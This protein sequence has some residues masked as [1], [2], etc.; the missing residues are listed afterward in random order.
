MAGHFRADGE[1]EFQTFF[2]GFAGEYVE[3]AVENVEKTKIDLFQHQFA[4]LDLGVVE[5]VVD[6]AE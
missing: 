4:G 6:D 5:D 3:E 1:D 2:R